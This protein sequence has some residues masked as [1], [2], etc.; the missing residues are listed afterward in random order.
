ML[1][2]N[3]NMNNIKNLIKK[4]IKKLSQFEIKHLI[5][6]LQNFLKIGATY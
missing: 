3:L 5:L 6:Y 2:Q 4:Q 1:N